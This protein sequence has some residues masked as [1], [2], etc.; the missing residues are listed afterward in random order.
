MIELV[1]TICLAIG[2]CKD[3]SL[4]VSDKMTPMQCL[5][6]SQVEAQKWLEHNPG[7]RIARLTC[8][9]VGRYARA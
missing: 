5:M 4:N 9:R 8:G 6:S 2:G 1:A 3:I 7:W